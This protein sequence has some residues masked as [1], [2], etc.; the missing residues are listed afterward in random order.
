[1]AIILLGD[2]MVLE[3][4]S[5]FDSP[6]VLSISVTDIISLTLS[7]YDTESDDVLIMQSSV[8]VGFLFVMERPAY[9]SS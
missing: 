7:E 4:D 2:T 1:M 3:S 8:Y 9:L 5:V 6:D